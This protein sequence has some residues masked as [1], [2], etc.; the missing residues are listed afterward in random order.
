MNI[1]LVTYSLKIGGIER[2]IFNQA[3]IFQESGHHVL[4]VESQGKGPWKTYFQENGIEVK[5]FE[6]PIF[7]SKA[8][9][10]KDLIN[11]LKGFDVLFIHDSPYVQAGIPSLPDRILVFTVLHSMLE[12]MLDNASGNLSSINKII[13]V[14]PYLSKLLAAQKQVESEKIEYIPTSV[15][16]Q[17]DIPV[18]P[19]Q[20]IGKKMLFIGRIE[21][22]EKA[23]M[24]L[25]DI[26]RKV[27]E[28]T[29]ISCLHIFGEGSDMEALQEKIIQYGLRDFMIIKGYLPY[30]QLF[31]TLAQYD[32]LILPSFFEGQGLVVLEAMAMGVIPIASRLEG[33]TTVWV[34]DGAQ[35]FLADPGDPDDF[36]RVISQN[37]N[38][39]D[40]L[41]ISENAKMVVRKGFTF[42]K[43]KERYTQLIADELQFPGQISRDQVINMPLLGDLPEVPFFLVKPLRKLL[44][45]LRL[46][47]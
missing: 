35:G 19:K 39:K 43:M 32:F 26:I 7:K 45:I 3:K 15:I 22:A 21:H 13:T 11:F 4:V 25:P 14:S 36:A 34:E 24:I 20:E 41:E 2:V 46:W 6:L 8:A 30:Q 28:D 12:S 47:K 17:Q 16:N 33:R 42:E 31:D 1:A 5:T 9:F 37:I 40:L 44:K 10:S 29:P 27:L 38:R 18:L 23:V